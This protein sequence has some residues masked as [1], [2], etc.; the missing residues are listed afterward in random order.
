MAALRDAG[1]LTATVS[2]FGER[3]AAWHWYAGYNEIYNPGK[4]G[5]DIADDVTHDTKKGSIARVQEG[6]NNSFAFAFAFVFAFA[7]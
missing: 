3:H 6:I 1:H 7:Y 5:M 2:S 4:W